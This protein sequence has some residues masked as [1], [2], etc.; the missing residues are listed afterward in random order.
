MFRA[1]TVEEQIMAELE[2]AASEEAKFLVIA[3]IMFKL[4]KE[5][6]NRDPPIRIR[7]CDLQKLL[8]FTKI[9]KGL[10]N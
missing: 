5:M 1:L 6:A 8:K 4:M 2:G 7:P 10:W 9:K 3:K